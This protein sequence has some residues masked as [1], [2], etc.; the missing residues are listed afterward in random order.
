MR[1]SILFLLFLPVLFSC[2]EKDEWLD[3]SEESGDIPAGISQVAFESNSQ[4][5]RVYVFRKEDNVFRYDTILNSEGSA[6]GKMTAQLRMGDYKFLF[7]GPLNGQLNVLP[8]LPDKTVTFEQL[9]FAAQADTEHPNA[10]LPVEELFLPEPEVADSVYA[11]RGD[12]EIKC[13]LKRRVSQLEFVLKRGYKKGN[14]YIPQPFEEG[15]NILGS[16]QEFQV[17]TTGVGTKCNYRGT[18]GEGTLFS[19]F[20]ADGEKSVDTQGFATFEGPYVLPAAD[21]KEVLLDISLVSV[22]GTAYPPLRLTG[23][24]E[25]NRKLKVVLWLNSTSFDVGITIHNLP[26]SERTDG[27]NGIW[28]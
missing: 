14:E 9:T 7:T 23:K 3:H 27:D 2:S 18:S 12:N 24:L 8:V 10:V 11:I 25:P 16:I 21:G 20:S 5:L 17:V 28:E 6:E 26:I 19:T 13:T 15:E 22:S 1:S 4:S